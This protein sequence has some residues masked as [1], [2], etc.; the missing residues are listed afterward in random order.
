M[1]SPKTG[2]L[3]LLFNCSFGGS[4]ESCNANEQFQRFEVNLDWHSSM[5]NLRPRATIG[6]ILLW[7]RHKDLCLLLISNSDSEQ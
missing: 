5:A 6:I 1:T 4:K 7:L 2:D 3:G